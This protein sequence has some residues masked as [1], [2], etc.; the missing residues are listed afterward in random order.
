[1]TV[2]LLPAL[3]SHASTPFEG[4]PGCSGP[5]RMTARRPGRLGSRGLTHTSHDAVGDP[6]RVGQDRQARVHGQ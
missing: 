4:R 6:L 1:V 2:R 5:R 3:G